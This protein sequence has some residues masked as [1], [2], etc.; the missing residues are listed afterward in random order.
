MTPIKSQISQYRQ[1][2]VQAESLNINTMGE[3]FLTF[4]M[5]QKI[6]TEFSDAATEKEKF[7]VV[8]KAEFRLLKNNANNILY[9]L[10]IIAFSANGFGRQAY[11]HLMKLQSL[12]NR[13]LI[14]VG[15]HDRCRAGR[16]LHV[17]FNIPYVF[18]YIT[19]F[20]G[21]QAE[22]ILNN[23]N[24]NVRRLDKEHAVA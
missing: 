23:V 19:K 18:G 10:R 12:L 11:A 17:V 2:F 20:C 14:A 15:N 4:T 21:T 24:P 5:V 6:M 1:K 16:E 8:T 22:V 7:A 3:V 9:I 13:V